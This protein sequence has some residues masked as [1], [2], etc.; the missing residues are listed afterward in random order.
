MVQKKNN[1]TQ[2][3]HS[4][5]WGRSI[6]VYVKSNPFYV[7][8]RFH[9]TQQHKQP[10]KQYNCDS[11]LFFFIC[12]FIFSLTTTSEANTAKFV[13]RVTLVE[14]LCPWNQ[15]LSFGLCQ[16]AEVI[17]FWW[18]CYRSPNTSGLLIC[19]WWL[20]TRSVIKFMFISFRD[21]LC[22]GESLTWKSLGELLHYYIQLSFVSWFNVSK[23]V[24]C[25]FI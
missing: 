9:N 20:S 12:N 25:Q 23:L 7:L 14:S 22:E 13:L 2:K 4:W 11:M 1:K 5:S 21:T 18:Y 19:E 17:L 10:Y 6:K 8:Y 3:V 15:K 16:K 24:I